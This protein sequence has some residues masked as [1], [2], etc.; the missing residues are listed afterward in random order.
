MLAWWSIGCEDGS[1]RHSLRYAKHN[2]S[3]GDRHWLLQFAL[4]FMTEPLSY[5]RVSL[6]EIVPMPQAEVAEL[7]AVA[8]TTQQFYQEVQYREEL[9][10]Y[11]DWYQQVSAQ[12]QQELMAMRQEVNLFGL[13][14]G[15]RQQ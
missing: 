11:Y 1:N 2:A 15:R 13:F 10:D 7:F 14:S 5:N 3:S 4:S 12:H 9:A 8:Q 6:S